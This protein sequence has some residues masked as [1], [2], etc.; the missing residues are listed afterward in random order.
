MKA[1]LSNIA[2]PAAFSHKSLG[3]G[4][5]PLLKDMPLLVPKTNVSIIP[6]KKEIVKNNFMCI[7]RGRA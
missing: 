2:M 5:P 4:V 1:V 6:I 7:L 3:L